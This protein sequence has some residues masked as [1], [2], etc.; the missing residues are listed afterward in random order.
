MEQRDEHLLMSSKYD[1]LL[2]EDENEEKYGYDNYDATMERYDMYDLRDALMD[3]ECY[4]KVSKSKQKEIDGI[5][6]K[7]S[8]INNLASYFILVTIFL[9]IPSWICIPVLRERNS[10]GM[11]HRNRGRSFDLL[12][13]SIH[14][15]LFR[16]N[17]VAVCIQVGMGCS[18]CSRHDQPVRSLHL[19]LRR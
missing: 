2:H 17:E 15:Q 1:Y 12:L 5:R 3:D 13:R 19:F 16:K 7:S 4:D 14:R 18:R 8:K 9:G 11:D 6:N 10:M